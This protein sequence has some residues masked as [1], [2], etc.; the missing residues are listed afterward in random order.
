VGGI[1]TG[2]ITAKTVD[3][4]GTRGYDA[5]A[6]FTGGGFTPTITGTVGG[7]TLT[8]VAG[9]VGT[10]PS[11]NVIAGTQTLTTG[12]LALGNG[13]GLA[14]NYTLVGGIDTGT[15]TA[16]TVDLAGTRGYDTTANFTGGGF[17]PT[18]TGTVGGE[19][20][21]IVAG[22]VG[23]VP[24]ANVIAGTQTLTTGTLALGNGTTGLASNYTL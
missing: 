12:T 22:G 14:S 2:T 10:V 13:T 1:D 6:N 4:A 9:G 5:T 11:A 17:T 21:T 23:T 18:I 3:L 19:T 16:K 7:E 24:S 15:I 8:I 20:L